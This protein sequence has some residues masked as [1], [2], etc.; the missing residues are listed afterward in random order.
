MVCFIFLYMTFDV[1]IKIMLLLT[2]QQC[3]LKYLGQEGGNY[4]HTHTHKSI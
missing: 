4:T 1:R 3:I 2:G